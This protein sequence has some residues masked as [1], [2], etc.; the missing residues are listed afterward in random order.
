M[1]KQEPVSCV[2][3]NCPFKTNIH[4]IFASHR[5]RKHTSHTLGFKPELLQRYDNPVNAGDD[6]VDEDD[7]EGAASKDHEGD[8]MKELPNLIEKRVL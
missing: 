5:I 8:E 2:F 3:E 4:G 1:E 6:P 7:T